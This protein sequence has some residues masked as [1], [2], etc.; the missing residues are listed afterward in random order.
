MTSAL[1]G[2]GVVNERKKRK[3]LFT[4]KLIK[5]VLFGCFFISVLLWSLSPYLIIGINGTSSIDGLVFVVNK[6]RFP[7]KREIA[8]F[9]PPVGNLYS[10]HI[11]FGKYII[12][13]GGDTVTIKGRDF[14]I[15]DLFIG[16]AKEYTTMGKK[17]EMSNSGVIPN[18][19]Y[20]MWTKHENSY[21]SRYQDINWIHKSS[22][23]GTVYHVF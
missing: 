18:D 16:A 9:Y 7:K 20:F 22:V 8:A 19:Y 23:F 12:G 14:Y 2:T 10:D 15:N 5:L 6:H 1:T 3:I 4:R 11:W 17:L 21:D 13:V